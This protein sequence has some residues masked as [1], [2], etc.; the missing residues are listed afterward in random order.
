[1][2]DDWHKQYS[3]TKFMAFNSMYL[4][5]R[6]NRLYWLCSQFKLMMSSTEM[7]EVGQTDLPCHHQPT[8]CPADYMEPFE[9]AC[10]AFLRAS[11]ASFIISLP[12]LRTL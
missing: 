6:V 3:D 10:T 4:S 11:T 12:L 7:V 5:L 2:M 1:M 8:Q 9:S